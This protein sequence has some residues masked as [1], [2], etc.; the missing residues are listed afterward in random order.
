MIVALAGGTGAA[1]LLRGLARVTEPAR[2]F[3]VGNTGDDLDWWGLRVSP[4]LDSVAYAL[5]GLLDGRRGWGV[6]DDTFHCLEAM[7]RLGRETWF[8]LGDRD[9]ATHLHRTLLL[10]AGA[11]LTDA[12]GAIADALGVRARLVPMSDD[13]VRTELRTRGG[14]LGLE[15]FF[16]RERCAPDVLEVAYRGADAARPA[17]GVLDA[18]AAAEAIVVCCSNPVT[19][20]GPILAV[21]GIADALVRTPAPVVA[22]SPIVGGQAVSGP[23]AKLLAARGLDVSPLGVAR[24]YRPWL[25]ALVMDGADAA[26]AAALEE[27][28]VRPVVADALMPDHAAE[29]RLARVVLD[30]AGAAA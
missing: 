9:L 5:A 22:V 6:R 24:A 4:D 13:P 27:D 23:A 11:S 25:D 3:V 14:W 15:E 21:P 2:L 7:H 26:Q 29:A 10:R 17:P 1:K 28:G 18:V 19:S 16:V 30:A 8:R 20:I 12:T